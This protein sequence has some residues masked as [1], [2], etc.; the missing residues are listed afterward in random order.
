MTKKV[1][2]FMDYGRTGYSFLIELLPKEQKE[3]VI[4]YSTP[5]RVEFKQGKAQ[6]KLEVIK[7]AGTLKDPFEWRVIYPIDMK[8]A[9]GQAREIGPQQY[10]VKTD[11]SEDR[12][13][14]LQFIRP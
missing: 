7:Q 6:Y 9:S 5:V 11:L 14:Q 2:S 1:T 8:L 4:D 12:I 10:S 3:L 13:F